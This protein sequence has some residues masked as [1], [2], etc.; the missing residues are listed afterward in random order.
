MNTTQ[1]SI[2]PL[3]ALAHAAMEA[4][5][6]SPDGKTVIL[7]SNGA[8]IDDITIHDLAWIHMIGEPR[9][10]RTAVALIFPP[11][12][13]TEVCH[14][15]RQLDSLGEALRRAGR[16]WDTVVARGGVRFRIYSDHGWLD[17]PET[18][19]MNNDDLDRLIDAFA[20]SPGRSRQ[21]DIARA[22]DAGEAWIEA[23]QGRMAGRP[24]VSPPSASLQAGSVR[25]AVI[26]WAVGETGTD[27]L[28]PG[29]RF[30]PPVQAP[31]PERIDI[32]LSLLAERV[33]Q[34]D[35]VH[36][37]A[38]ASYLAW[39]SGYRRLAAHLCY[40]ARSTG[41][42]SRLASLVWT[43]LVRDIVPQ[44]M[45]ETVRPA[46]EDRARP[47]RPFPGSAHMGDEKRS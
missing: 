25:D 19:T 16:S 20:G 9:Q 29:E 47:G 15:A 38:C 46:Q 28:M 21:F 41:Q 30:V 44:W 4:T 1:H 35:T 14:A 33:G 36:A 3:S 23:L 11:H 2:I 6:Y 40:R 27:R 18:D 43:A 8:G 10:A 42:R 31:N 13:D 26:V 17:E 34:P 39:W 22:V 32:A 5:N 7:Y 12:R 45:R 37:L 24:I